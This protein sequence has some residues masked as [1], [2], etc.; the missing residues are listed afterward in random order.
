MHDNLV[1][2]QASSV[3]A[4]VTNVPL[5]GIGHVELLFRRDVVERVLRELDSRRASAREE[6][7]KAA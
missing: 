5:T 1:A 6:R 3:L 2:P 7:V 4:N